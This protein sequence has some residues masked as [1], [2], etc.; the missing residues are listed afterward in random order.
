VPLL[1]LTWVE[2]RPHLEV[3]GIT[4]KNVSL[5]AVELEANQQPVIQIEMSP[6][7]VTVLEHGHATWIVTCPSCHKD[8]NHTCD[9]A[10]G[11]EMG[12]P[13]PVAPPEMPLLD[14]D[15]DGRVVTVPVLPDPDDD[16]LSF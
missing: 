11:R 12:P 4:L 10:Q 3:D 2:G 7:A 5:V 1:T 13:V 15:H 8:T 6:D 16:N 14:L 9:L